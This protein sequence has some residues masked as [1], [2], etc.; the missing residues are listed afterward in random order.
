MVCPANTCKC[1]F[2]LNLHKVNKYFKTCNSENKKVISGN[3]ISNLVLKRSADLDNKL[4]V[5]IH[6]NVW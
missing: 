2:L 3:Q 6:G 5:I 4:V 1:A